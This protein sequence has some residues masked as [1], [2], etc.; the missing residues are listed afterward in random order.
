MRNLL[1]ILYRPKSTFERVRDEG[2][3]I[4]PLVVLMLLYVVGNWMTVSTLLDLSEKS[5]MFRGDPEVNEIFSYAVLP[6]AAAG[7][8]I[9]V[10]AGGLFLLLI[11]LL[12]RGEAQYLDLVKVMVFSSLPSIIQQLVIG[13][14]MFFSNG[15]FPIVTLLSPTLELNTGYVLLTAF[16][17]LAF[18]IWSLALAIIGA[19]VMM[20][21]SYW[22]VG[23][24]MVGLSVLV[25]VLMVWIQLP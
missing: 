14:L 7:Y 12:V 8:L 20:E 3:W 11:N 23:G 4:I 22:K 2:G 9:G 10:F 24:W 25:L 16:A 6:S 5:L 15:Y 13:S 17:M 1:T 19:G 18:S 21:R